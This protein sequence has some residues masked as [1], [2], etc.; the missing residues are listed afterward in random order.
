MDTHDP[1]HPPLDRGGRRRIADRRVR[2]S[3]YDGAERRTGLRRRSGF[4]RRLRKYGLDR[5]ERRGESPPSGAA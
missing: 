1:Y 3:P 2:L 4:D 5:P